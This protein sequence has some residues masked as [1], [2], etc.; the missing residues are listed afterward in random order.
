M[1]EV[2]NEFRCRVFATHMPCEVKDRRT[3]E[4]YKVVGVS[5]DE[6]NFQVDRKYE[7]DWWN[8]NDTYQILLTDLS[9]ITKEHAV[10]ASKFL[11]CFYEDTRVTCIRQKENSEGKF[12]QLYFVNSDLTEQI[13]ANFS[14][15]RRCRISPCMGSAYGDEYIKAADYL[16]KE[17]YDL[18]FQGVDLVEAG[19]A[20]LKS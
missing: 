16:R 13:I 12:A 19:I 18:H 11:N 14:G 6:C 2:T 20:I 5:I 3:N 4:I 1:I 15:G 10:Q 9:Q 7:N 17:G 8:V